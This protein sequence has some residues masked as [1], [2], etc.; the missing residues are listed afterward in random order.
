[1]HD[2]LHVMTCDYT[3]LLL[4]LFLYIEYTQ[5]EES[6]KTVS[7]NKTVLVKMKKRF[8]KVCIF[9]CC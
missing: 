5:Q 6:V 1:M 8:F 2:L 4:F 3:E 9:F 7:A